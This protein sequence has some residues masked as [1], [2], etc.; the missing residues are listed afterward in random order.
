MDDVD[1]DSMP[2]T[3]VEAFLERERG[4]RALL[5][6]L[7]KLSIEGRHDEVHER[8]RNLAEHDEAVFYT[9]AF[10][11]SGSK[12]F[13]GDVEA[14]LDVTAADRLRDLSETYGSLTDAFAIVRTE[15]SEDRRNPVTDL[16]YTVSY[17]RGVESPIVGYQPRSGERELFES[18]GTPSEVLHLSTD[19]VEAT[20]DALDVALEEGYSVNTEELSALIDR[21]EELESALS[22]LRDDLDELRRKPLGDE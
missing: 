2:R 18:R 6:E 11:L 3:I 13:F 14:Q 4:T 20:T 9:V 15:V 8:V 21:R 22:R 16:S 5:D 17:H 10:S 19:L 1:G 7:E 12:Q